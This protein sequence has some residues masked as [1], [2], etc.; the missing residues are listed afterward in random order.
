[1]HLLLEMRRERLRRSTRLQLLIWWVTVLCTW[2]ASLRTG[3]TEHRNERGDRTLL[4]A[5]LLLVVRPGAPCS[6]L[7][8]V[9]MPFAPSSVLATRLDAA[10][11][12]RV[13]SMSQTLPRQLLA[14]HW[15]PAKEDTNVVTHVLSLSHHSTNGHG[16]CSNWFA[17]SFS[18]FLSLSRPLVLLAG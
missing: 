15:R 8:L 13:P 4:V 5:S 2:T 3:R 6:F 7:F 9:A 18:L 12:T 10:F 1:M 16:M 17:P 11:S 14:N